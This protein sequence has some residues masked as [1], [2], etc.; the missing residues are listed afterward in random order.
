MEK[1]KESRGGERGRNYQAPCG[2]GVRKREGK[3]ISPGSERQR[4]PR[5]GEQKGGKATS[6]KKGKRRQVVRRKSR[7]EKRNSLQQEG[8]ERGPAFGLLRKKI[9]VSG[10]GTWR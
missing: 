9:E 1:E 2:V 7:E 8:G 4:T 6:C 5:G 3:K 10:E